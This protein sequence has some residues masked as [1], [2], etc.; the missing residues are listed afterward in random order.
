MSETNEAAPAP[1]D[2]PAPTKEEEPTKE[3]EEKVEVKEE[4]PAE[5][6]KPAE[7]A[8]EGEK[9]AEDGAAQGDSK[10]LKELDD[11][12]P[13]TFPQ[14]VRRMLCLLVCIDGMSEEYRLIKFC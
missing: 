12:A 3:P 2:A 6:E 5:G 14:V 10:L 8:K 9:P 4:K 1:A 11:E 13:K 7:P